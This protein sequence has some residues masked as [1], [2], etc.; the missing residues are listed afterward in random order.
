MNN[1]QLKIENEQL[2]DNAE[3]EIKR[4]SDFVDTFTQEAEQNKKKM[5]ADFESKLSQERLKGED[6]RKQFVLEKS[7]L[8]MKVSKM[9]KELESMKQDNMNL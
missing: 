6:M 9:S 7:D 2:L 4:M 1:N 8:E 3:S 5:S